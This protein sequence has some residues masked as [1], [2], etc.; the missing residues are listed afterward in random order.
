MNAQQGLKIQKYM[1]GLIATMSIAILGFIMITMPTSIALVNLFLMLVGLMAI[2]QLFFSSKRLP[3]R[4][5]LLKRSIVAN[6]CLLL[7]VLPVL[8]F[9]ARCLFEEISRN[10]M[11]LLSFMN[12]A[13]FFNGYLLIGFQN[14]VDVAMEKNYRGE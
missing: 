5:E 11:I 9:T 3:N 4:T 7:S 10:E 13:Y 1:S 2:T 6:V 12:M 14:A 8:I